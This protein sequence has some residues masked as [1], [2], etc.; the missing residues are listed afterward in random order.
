MGL[1][2]GLEGRGCLKTRYLHGCNE[3]LGY[4]GV[5]WQ[6]VLYRVRNVGR[7]RVVSRVRDA[8]K[9][10]VKEKAELEEEG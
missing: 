1:G 5:L 10:A 8:R 2:R 4:E 6:G 3:R 7:L 9:G